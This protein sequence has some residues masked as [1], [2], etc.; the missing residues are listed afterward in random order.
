MKFK[1]SSKDKS[2]EVKVK[3]D[4]VDDKNKKVIYTLPVTYRVLKNSEFQSFLDGL[5]PEVDDDGK[6][7]GEPV[8]D[9][10]KLTEIM[11]GNILDIKGIIDDED[12]EVAFDDDLL[13]SVLEDK[14]AVMPIINEFI[15]LNSPLGLEGARRKN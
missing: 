7:I 6:I 3:F 5:K 8:K 15:A 9:I 1:V 11:H 4:S 10:Q 2:V 12:N 13:Y 14:D